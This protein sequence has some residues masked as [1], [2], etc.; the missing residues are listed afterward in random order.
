VPVLIVTAVLL[1]TS[2]TFPDALWYTALQ[3]EIPEEAISRVSA[4]D[5]LGSFAL[6]PLGYMLAA[7]LIA[8]GAQAAL[9]ALAGLVVA[10]TV[11]SLLAPGVR[12][13]KRRPPE[14]DAE[15]SIVDAVP[16]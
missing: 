5:H 13:L 9:L 4:F 10:A 3:Q 16:A 11:L 2:M 1:G 8:V 6:R 15:K 14:P 12:N 7:A